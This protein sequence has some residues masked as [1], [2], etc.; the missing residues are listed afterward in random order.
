MT[1]QSLKPG[2]FLLILQIILIHSVPAFSDGLQPGDQPVSPSVPYGLQL[3]QELRNALPLVDD[4]PSIA[5]ENL[6][7]INQRFNVLEKESPSGIKEWIGD[8]FT[9]KLSDRFDQWFHEK[10]P[11]PSKKIVGEGLIVRDLELLDGSLKADLIFTKMNADNEIRL[12]FVRAGSG[13]EIGAKRI[14]SDPFEAAR[15]MYTFRH[16]EKIEAEQFKREIHTALTQ[17]ECSKSYDDT[18]GVVEAI[19]GIIFAL[20]PIG[21][22][23]TTQYGGGKPLKES[24]RTGEGVGLMKE[25]PGANG[26]KISIPVQ[27]ALKLEIANLRQGDLIRAKIDSGKFGS[28]ILKILEV[29]EDY[30]MVEHPVNPQVAPSILI[31]KNKILGIEKE[32]PTNVTPGLI[33]KP[34]VPAQNSL[35]EPATARPIPAQAV[36]PQ[37]LSQLQPG[38]SVQFEGSAKQVWIVSGA[39]IENNK[40]VIEIE[41]SVKLEN[42]KTL[43]QLRSISPSH[44][45]SITQVG[46]RQPSE[47]LLAKHLKGEPV[48]EPRQPEAVAPAVDTPFTGFHALQPGESIVTVAGYIRLNN[49]P[50]EPSVFVSFNRGRTRV[51]EVVKVIR[52]E[53]PEGLKVQ[54]VLVRGSNSLVEDPIR[55]LV[56]LEP[57]QI[58][59]TLGNSA[60]NLSNPEKIPVGDRIGIGRDRPIDVQEFIAAQ[61]KLEKGNWVW[62]E[63]NGVIRQGMLSEIHGEFVTINVFS[64]GLQFEGPYR[65]ETFT[66]MVKTVSEI[67]QVQLFP[68]AV[69]DPIGSVALGQVVGSVNPGTSQRKFEEKDFRNIYTSSQAGSSELT[70]EMKALLVRIRMEKGAE[71]GESFPKIGDGVLL[72][73]MNPIVSN[74]TP[75]IVTGI[76]WI[77]GQEPRLVVKFV[78]SDPSVPSLEAEIP[79]GFID[80]IA[81]RSNAIQKNLGN[82]TTE[83]PVSG[84][85]VKLEDGTLALVEGPVWPGP[86]Q[87]PQLLVKVLEK[88]KTPASPKVEGEE[89][90][91]SPIEIQAARDGVQYEAL[92]KSRRVVSLPEVLEV[93]AKKPEAK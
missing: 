70:P 23:S 58:T 6:A 15:N 89:P 17:F 49:K 88:S 51:F 11:R 92:I 54:R 24:M 48:S 63:E 22:K 65:A 52:Q 35:P 44:I 53:T 41:L 75:G 9:F 71:A 64:R 80:S 3:F 79:L 50:N 62:F 14:F 36:T 86:N 73:S 32:M 83:L 19:E 68:P 46:S 87:C 4:A 57:K 12:A 43:K 74:G 91:P 31:P 34:S 90:P 5:K 18:V 25:V 26:Y 82:G 16:F 20:A 38:D 2:S 13:M 1:K 77:K 69:A 56:V 81:R 59:E 84:N 27:E 61:G 10:F 37:I 28:E 45:T 29:K 8:I 60:L 47:A 30:V 55:N 42:G 39:R 76:N 66:T 33:S 21:V 85:Y 67:N 93:F 7:P 72:N 40:P 78:H